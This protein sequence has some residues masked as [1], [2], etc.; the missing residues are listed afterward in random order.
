MP[1]RNSADP[2]RSPNRNG[3][4]PQIPPANTGSPSMSTFFSDSPDSPMDPGMS[5]TI[6]DC[7]QDWGH[8]SRLDRQG[9]A[10]T[11]HPPPAAVPDDDIA[12]WLNS[13]PAAP[14]G[15]S[16]NGS[17]F[18]GRLGKSQT[19][20]T[21]RAGNSANE[22]VDP[23]FDNDERRPSVASA[24]TVS[25]QNST[26]VSRTSTG[27]GAH[28]RRL[29]AFFGDDARDSA[30]SSHTS[31]LTT[32]RD[33]SI[34]SQNRKARHNSVQTNNTDGRPVSPSSSRPRS[35]LPSSDVTPWLFQDFKVSACDAVCSCATQS[36][37]VCQPFRVLC[38]SWLSVC[39]DEDHCLSIIVE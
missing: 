21:S 20:P 2:R 6:R 8:S 23:M 16:E 26:P 27:R 32:N 35:P 17:P 33:H 7:D 4:A 39:N 30:R 10:P 37:C 31:I 13:G 22:P 25:S 28:S 1:S 15:P 34:S 12:P 11:R 19:F 3:R 38:V 14:N 24:T 9:P 36:M 5:N 29:G 18:G